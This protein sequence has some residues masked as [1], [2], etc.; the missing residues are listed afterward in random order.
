MEIKLSKEEQIKVLEDVIRRIGFSRFKM[1]LCGDT[2]YSIYR[3]CD[4]D[5]YFIKNKAIHG[6][7]D[8]FINGFNIDNAMLLSA[9]YGFKTPNGKFD[10]YWWRWFDTINIEEWYAPRIA[11]IKAL[12]IELGVVKD[13]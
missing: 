13:S 11:F 10:G 9:K 8:F 6:N 5:Y 2:I 12:I 3:I 4:I 1:G 7:L